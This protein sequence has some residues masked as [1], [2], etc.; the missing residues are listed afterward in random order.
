MEDEQNQII[1]FKNKSGETEVDVKLHDESVWLTQAQIADLFEK[2]RSVVTKHIKNIIQEGELEDSVCAKFAQTASDNKLYQVQYYNL[3]MII[4]VGYRVNSK[5]GIEF[6]RWAN[7]VLKEYLAQGYSINQS[8]ITTKNFAE[9]KQ[10][11]ELLSNTLINQELVNEE[12][13]EVLHL[14]KTYTKTWEVLLKYDEDG[15][16]IPLQKHSSSKIIQYEDIKIAINSLKAELL[17][18]GEA[19]A[20]FGQE[21][22]EALQG[23]IGN[24]YQTFDDQDLYPS[25]QEKAAHLLY[26]IIKDHP[27]S[28]GNKRIGCLLFLYF[29]Q[30]NKMEGSTITPEGLT[31]L[32]LL[33][34]GSNPSDKEIMIKLIVNLL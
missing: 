19:T 5:R 16:D 8:R 13:Q 7:K 6:R 4:S 33:V 28:D 11:M 1:I 3:D 29:M 17:R 9:L 27:F 10:V 30:F 32:A 14:I 20:L 24:I 31:S 25:A 12:G 18:K 2:E 21:R 34:A 26:F 22:G 15:L 23:I